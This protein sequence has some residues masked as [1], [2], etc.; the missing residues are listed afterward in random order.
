MST[1]TPRHI[2][3]EEEKQAASTGLS[4]KDLIIA[5]LSSVAAALIVS[6]FW[7]NGTL[8]A[9]AMT[10]VIV[11]IARELLA[12]PAETVGSAAR[13]I[14]AVAPAPAARRSTLDDPEPPR[15][16]RARREPTE[17]FDPIQPEGWDELT[18]AR[19]RPRDPSRRDVPPTRR[20]PVRPAPVSQRR[21]EARA[22]KANHRR[23]NR[24]VKLGLVTGLAAAVI[25][26][27]TITLTEV[28]VFGK[29][30]GGGSNGTT[31]T[32]SSS[33]TDSDR[34]KDE[35]KDEKT[36]A[37]EETPTPSATPEESPQDE[38]TPTPT[39]SA[40]PTPSVSPAPGEV[41]E[42]ATPAPSPAPTP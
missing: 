25:A 5:A 6:Q 29:S 4:L 12:R 34:K 18:G 27:A 14:S 10:P 26:V 41:P 11:A 9:T 7:R 38:A 21:A 33:S 23:R 37:D 13:K 39:P 40:T 35:S 17:D 20:E 30:L 19:G 28:T 42:G 36:P 24:A 8:I 15:P 3:E 31:F 32:R 1:R 22:Q 16:A 2:D